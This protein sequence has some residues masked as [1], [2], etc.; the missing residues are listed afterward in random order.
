MAREAEATF[1]AL[2]KKPRRQ[3]TVRI[4][5]TGDD[6]EPLELLFRMQA[7]GSKAY[8]ALVAKFPPK[9]E[10]KKQGAI[11]DHER[12]APALVAACSESPRLTEDEARQ[13]F[14]SEDWSGGEFGALFLGALRLCNAGLD[15][16]FSVSG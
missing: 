15:V 10:D 2:L 5:S 13:L 9:A 12:F 7:I 11:Y 8:D 4:T 3:D 14:D 6:G 1:E 16:P